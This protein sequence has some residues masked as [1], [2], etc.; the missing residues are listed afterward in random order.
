MVALA[1]AAAL[2]GREMVPAIIPRPCGAGKRC[3]FWETKLFLMAACRLACSM[4]SERVNLGLGVGL[5]P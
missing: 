2:T 1:P 5:A 4:T 3:S